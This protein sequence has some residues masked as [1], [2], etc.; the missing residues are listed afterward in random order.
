MIRNACFLPL[1]EIFLTDLGIIGAGPA[2][3]TAA[4]YAKRAGLTLHIFERAVLGGQIS[5]SDRIENYTAIAQIS[6][7]DFCAAL[8][9]QLQTLDIT[10]V[11]DDVQKITKNGGGFRL[12]GTAG[13]YSAKTVLLANGARPRK[14]AIPGEETYMGRGVSYCAHCDGAFFK[15]KTVAV[16]GG[17]N[18]AAESAL[19]L[20]KICKKVLVVYRGEKLRAEFYLNAQL[21]KTKNIECIWSCIPVEICGE[22]TVELLRVR[23]TKTQEISALPVR[24]VFVSIGREPQ[25]NAFSALVKL[26]EAGYVVADAACR[27]SCPGV[28]AAGDARQKALRQIITACADGALAVSSIMDF[29]F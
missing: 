4:I 22:N 26:D 21:Q 24:G 7:M 17:G 3:I 29:L 1:G 8:A 20:S 9:E 6:G 27:T 25:N 15:N 11:R 5:E 2:G 16:I 14:L 28:F 10:P 19:Y 18:S 12:V 13:T 23:H